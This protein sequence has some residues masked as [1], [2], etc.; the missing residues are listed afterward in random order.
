M[1][2]LPLCCGI[3][4]LSWRFEG[5]HDRALRL[6]LFE[7]L[8]NGRLAFAGAFGVVS[9]RGQVVSLLCVLFRPFEVFAPPHKVIELN[10]LS[11]HFSL[12]ATLFLLSWLVG[13]SDDLLSAYFHFV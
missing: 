8:W 9:W 13:C 12:L 11:P 1:K 10:I 4:I 5:F 7:I 6:E 2:V 3:R